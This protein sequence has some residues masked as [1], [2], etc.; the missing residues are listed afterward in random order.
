MTQYRSR[1]YHF[2]DL[3]EKLTPEDVEKREKRSEVSKY[4]KKMKKRR[5]QMTR[6]QRKTVA[7]NPWRPNTGKSYPFQAQYEPLSKHEK[8]LGYCSLLR[9]PGYLNPDK[10]RRTTPYLNKDINKPRGCQTAVSGVRI[11]TIGENP[12]IKIRRQAS[13]FNKLNN[14]NGVL[15]Y[16][17]RAFYM[18]RV[19]NLWRSSRS[20][21]SGKERQAGNRSM[22]AG[23]KK[24]SR[25]S[26][27]RVTRSFTETG[28]VGE[29]KVEKKVNRLISAGGVGRGGDAGPGGALGGGFGELNISSSVDPK[30]RS[31]V[32]VGR[33]NTGRG[34]KS[35]SRPV[36]R[37]AAVSSRK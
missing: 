8:I 17:K 10:W 33:K 2:S 11:P 37:S 27:V 3:P 20:A 32:G 1:G 15:E 12:N 24:G 29:G 26:G 31:K 30:N 36:R 14:G 19:K 22:N 18:S 13:V 16:P 9:K 4:F 5:Q 28:F 23:S 6:M 34:K 35:S 25:K 7:S 21:R